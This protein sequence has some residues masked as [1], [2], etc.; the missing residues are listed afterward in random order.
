MALGRAVHHLVHRYIMYVYVVVRGSE[1]GYGHCGAA[2]H[3][4]KAP[5][6][7]V[8]AEELVCTCVTERRVDRS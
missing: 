2:E 7:L 3:S 5:W 1:L 6:N 4:S 8:R